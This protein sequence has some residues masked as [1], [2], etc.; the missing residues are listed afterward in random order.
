MYPRIL[1]DVDRPVT[2]D[3]EFYDKLEHS[4]VSVERVDDVLG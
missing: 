4:N 1:S 2:V 3:A